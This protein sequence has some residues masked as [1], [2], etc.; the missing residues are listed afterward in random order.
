MIGFRT[1]VEPTRAS[2]WVRELDVRQKLAMLAAAA[3]LVVL[4]DAV[5]T[6]LAIFGVVVILYAASG[7]PASKLRLAA[8]IA[9]LTVW[10]T[11]LAQALFYSQVPRTVMLELI[12]RDLPVLGSLT[13][14]LFIYKE[15][16]IYGAVQSLRIVTLVSF[17]LLVCWTTDPGDFLSALVRVRLPV[18]VAFM[19]VTSMRFLPTVVAEA[20]VVMTARRM[21][22]YHLRRRWGLRRLGQ[23]VKPIFANAIRRARTLAL[24]VESRGFDPSAQRTESRKMRMKGSGVALVLILAGI[25]LAVAI[26]K[27]LYWL[28]MEEVFYSPELRFLYDFVRTYL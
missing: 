13:G 20:G 11:C 27:M 10:S 18:G 17:G 21:K 14:G 23:V 24:S 22:G 26:L 19:T 25:V 28:Y 15:G 1:L 2:R 6:L 9:L 4:I 5:W 12:A 8:A 16:F 7:L 3:L